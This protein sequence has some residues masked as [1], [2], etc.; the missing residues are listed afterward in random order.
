MRMDHIVILT[1][2]CIVAQ[3][4]PNPSCFELLGF[5]ILLDRTLRPHL[6]EVN[7]SPALGIDCDVDERVKV[8]L[9]V[10]VLDTLGLRK[11]M[12]YVEWERACAAT[13][14]RQTYRE[15]PA[16]RGTALREDSKG[17]PPLPDGA[18]RR[19]TAIRRL[20]CS[21]SPNAF[22]CPVVLW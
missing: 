21:P 2:L 6:I 10:D 17:A 9:I 18:W 14:G 3:V 7:C 22:P 4:P 20:L 12:S 19:D 5:D 16:R 1:L 11:D 13:H 8:P 15:R